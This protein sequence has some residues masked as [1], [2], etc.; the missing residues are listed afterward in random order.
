MDLCPTVDELEQGCLTGDI[1]IVS[2]TSHSYATVKILRL[3][4]EFN[5][6]PVDHDHSC[7]PD[8][9]EARKA[10]SSRLG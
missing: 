6:A 10:L 3:S 4:L 2:P 5:K 7:S 9:E 1:S 8:P